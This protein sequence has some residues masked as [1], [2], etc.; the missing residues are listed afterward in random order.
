MSI[1]TYSLASKSS[2]VSDPKGLGLSAY[3]PHPTPGTSLRATTVRL[4]VNR[5]RSSGNSLQARSS[6]AKALFPISL[7]LAPN[8]ASAV[9]MARLYHSVRFIRHYEFVLVGFLSC[10]VDVDASVLFLVV[11]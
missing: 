8:V 7:P 4:G 9:S 3:R 2:H 10:P 1:W 6:M 5:S 11:F